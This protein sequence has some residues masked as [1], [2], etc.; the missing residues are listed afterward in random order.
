MLTTLG[1]LDAYFKTFL[2]PAWHEAYERTPVKYKD[3]A[4]VIPS[5]GAENT[6]A[7]MDRV[8]KLR[9]WI[10]ERQHKNMQLYPTTIVNEEYEDTFDIPR[11]KFE[12]DQQGLFGYLPAAMA[13]AAAKWPDY[14]VRDVLEA[15]EST[16]CYDGQDFFATA[17]PVNPMD[18]PKGT[19]SNLQ[20]SCPLT[21]DN[22]ASQIA[23]MRLLVGADG[24]KLSVEPDTLIVHPDQA[25]VA[26]QLI[27]GQVLAQAGSGSGATL[28]VG[29]YT[30]TIPMLA[31]LKL[32]IWNDLTLSG[33]WYLADNSKGVRPMIF[34]QRLAPVMTPVIDPSSPNVFER[35]VFT[36]GTRARG[37]AGFSLPFLMRKM[38]A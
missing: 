10:G 28:N 24:E 2:A 19:Y 13:S 4:T 11:T 33:K 29:G 9:K 36:W 16:L 3:V 34:Q 25:D 27:Y 8:A 32:E 21:R 22:L 23:A 38:A 14:L 5:T 20:T 30:N 6:Y 1:N 37:A 12:D 31:K 7:W 17:H 35:G 18:A 15:G 26:V